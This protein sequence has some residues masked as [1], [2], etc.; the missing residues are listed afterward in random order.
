MSFQ[1]T[2]DHERVLEIQ[3]FHAKRLEE[4]F[5]LLL[6]NI[7]SDEYL[8]QN[9]NKKKVNALFMNFA[10]VDREVRVYCII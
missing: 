7:F 5:L 3:Q 1:H 4:G 2:F 10:N 6:I 8:Q 9:T